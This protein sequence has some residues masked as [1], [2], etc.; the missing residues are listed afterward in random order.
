MPSAIR[1]F[2]LPRTVSGTKQSKKLKT[3]RG[4]VSLEVFFRRSLRS[5]CAELFCDQQ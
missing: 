4:V 2:S 1:L 5:K 3:C